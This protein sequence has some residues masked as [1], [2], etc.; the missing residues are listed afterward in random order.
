MRRGEEGGSTDC[1]VMEA[2]AASRRGEIR[3]RMT[4]QN[5][6][7]IRKKPLPRARKIGGKLEKH[8]NSCST[9]D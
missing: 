7:M 3:T 2:R 6:G 4:M 5:M 9:H 8:A 1:V